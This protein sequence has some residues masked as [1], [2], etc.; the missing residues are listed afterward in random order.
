[1]RT[2]TQTPSTAAK[3]IAAVFTAF[4]IIAPVWYVGSCIFGSSDDGADEKEQKKYTKTD[5][6]IGS[7][8][9]VEKRLVSPGSAEWAYG[10][11]SVTKI[12]DTTFSVLSYVDSQ[13]KFGALLRTYYK[14]EMVF[15]PSTGMMECKNLK[16]EEQ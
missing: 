12:N 16:L 14:C 11:E 2:T 1:M 5:A 6:L 15:I 3:V 7:H 4:I 13:N 10:D 8:Q 9:F